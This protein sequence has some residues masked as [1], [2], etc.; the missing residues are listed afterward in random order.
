MAR[1]CEN[2]VL[3][4]NQVPREAEERVDCEFFSCSRILR[5]YS[6]IQDSSEHLTYS[7]YQVQNTAHES[8]PANSCFNKH[9]HFPYFSPSL[10]SLALLLNFHSSH[11]AKRKVKRDVRL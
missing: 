10:C 8:V 1:H 7:E 2:L 6:L 11:C 4:W 5:S 3:G 9:Y